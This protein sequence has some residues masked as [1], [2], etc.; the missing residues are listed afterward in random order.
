MLSRYSQLE[1]QVHTE[2]KNMAI[3]E[4]FH[5]RSFVGETSEQ[6]SATAAMVR[7]LLQ[8]DFET[9]RDAGGSLVVREKLTGAPPATS[10]ASG[11]SRLSSPSSS[12]RRHAVV[13]VQTVLDRRPARKPLSPVRSMPSWPTGVTDK[14][15]IKLSD[16]DR[17]SSGL[18][19]VGSGQ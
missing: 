9:T 12:P 5:G 11:S 17:S 4:A 16:F 3:V 10:F 6:R 1:S 14:H 18:S 13:R 7:R 15:S 19:A 2:R 8:D